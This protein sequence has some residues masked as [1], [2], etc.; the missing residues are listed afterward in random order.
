MYF[1]TG[2]ER[3]SDQEAAKFR[4]QITGTVI[5]GH[6]GDTLQPLPSPNLGNDLYQIDRIIDKD[7]SE[8]TGDDALARAGNLPSR[9]SAREVQERSRLRV[10][11]L[12][13][14]SES[15]RKVIL[16]I[17]NQLVLHARHNLKKEQTVTL[18]GH[19]G[20]VWKPVNAETLKVDFKMDLR[21][22]SKGEESTSQRRTDL[23][24][25]LQFAINPNVLQ[26]FQ[27][28]QRPF[29]FFELWRLL[30]ET[31]EIDELELA[32]PGLTRGE[33]VNINV[34]PQ[35]ID[36]GNAQSNTVPGQNGGIPPDGTPREAVNPTSFGQGSA[37]IA[38]GRPQGT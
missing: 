38:G 1:H 32:F 19:K 4:N 28:S 12:E 7:F 14:A 8:I 6:I 24:Q 3:L 11:R 2:E 18:L 20:L 17:G 25:I 27:Q 5:E 9:T 30:M 21:V 31:Y 35:G 36:F 29:E 10:L 15:V 13:E 37:G 23:L 33:E 16:K 22:L 34:V 26:L